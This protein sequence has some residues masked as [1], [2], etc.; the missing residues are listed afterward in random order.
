MSAE[1]SARQRS[2]PTVS[3][4]GAGQG[5]IVI[6]VCWM[7]PGIRDATAQP[8]NIADETSEEVTT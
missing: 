2:R 6:C 4:D 8:E 7:W 1:P 5:E 3:S